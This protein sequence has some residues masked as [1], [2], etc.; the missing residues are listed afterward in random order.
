MSSSDDEAPSPE[1]GA[2]SSKD[3]V[4]PLQSESADDEDELSV[5]K[6][7]SG[8][9]RPRV[10][11]R[12]VMRHEKGDEAVMGEDEMKLQSK[13][14]SNQIME[15]SRMVR[16]P[17]HVPAPTDVGLWKLKSANIMHNAGHMLQCTTAPWLIDSDVNVY[18][19]NLMVLSTLRFICEANIMRTVIRPTREGQSI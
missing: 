8:Y 5:S 2:C 12:E 4:P 1:T 19:K 3:P 11:W 14:A 18:L 13:P 7:K 10:E 17:G 16:L 6:R 9:R 15:E